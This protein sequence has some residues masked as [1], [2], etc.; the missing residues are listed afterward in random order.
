MHC[1]IHGKEQIMYT[2]ICENSIDGILTGVYDAYADRHPR[3][4]IHLNAHEP[5]NLSLFT[6]YLTV[7]PDSEKA[8]KVARTL[9]SR[10]GQEFYETIYQAAMSGDV[11]GKSTMDK[12]DAIYGTISLALACGDGTKTLLSLGEP[13]VYRV[14]ELCRATG[15]EAM[16]LLGFVRFRE[17]ESGILFSCIH[18]KHHVLPILGE[19]F[20][21]RLPEE[22]FMI[23]DE[24]R[25]I[26]ALHPAHKGFFLADAASL[27]LAQTKRLSSDEAHIQSL[28]LTFFNSITIDARKNAGLQSQMIP[29]RFQRDVLEFQA[30]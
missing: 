2:Y 13:C 10:F 15:K 30:S 9:K 1:Q 17:L 4:E 5:E 19:H 26:A 11:R 27:D 6:Q 12:A 22:N 18:P 21:D 28:W 29:K 8:A 25:R 24:N 23:Y 20:S 14:F 3:N 7:K 16:H